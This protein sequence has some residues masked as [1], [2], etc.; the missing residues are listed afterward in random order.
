[1]MDNSVA[2]CPHNMGQA[3][4]LHSMAATKPQPIL[5]MEIGGQSQQQQQQ[6]G[7]ILAQQ[8][9]Q[10]SSSSSSSSHAHHH[11]HQQS[12]PSSQNLSRE[13]LNLILV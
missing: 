1:M 7:T 13:F 12:H 2:G 6:N 3:A 9:G 4:N 8:C 10:N 5:P 11:H